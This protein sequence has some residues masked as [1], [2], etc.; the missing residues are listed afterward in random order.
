MLSSGKIL[1]FLNNLVTCDWS[2]PYLSNYG[3]LVIL[4]VLV[5]SLPMMVGL[6]LHY[7]ELDLAFLSQF[8]VYFG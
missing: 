6:L 4:C 7:I 1:V 8:C 3:F 2:R 5:P